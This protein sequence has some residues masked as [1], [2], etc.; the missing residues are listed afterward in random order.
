[1]V[2]VPAV[3]DPA[4]ADEALRVDDAKGLNLEPVPTELLLTLPHTRL[5]T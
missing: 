3:W 2:A 4:G 1:M 5:P